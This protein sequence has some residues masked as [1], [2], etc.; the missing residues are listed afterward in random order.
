[1]LLKHITTSPAIRSLEEAEKKYRLCS[2]SEWN[3]KKLRMNG[4]LTLDDLFNATG[5]LVENEQEETRRKYFLSEKYL[6]RIITLINIFMFQRNQKHNE[7]INQLSM[8][9]RKNGLSSSGIHILQNLG[10]ASTPKTFSKKQASISD[11]QRPICNFNQVHWYDN[12]YRSLKGYFLMQGHTS[13]CY[14]AHGVTEILD[15]EPIPINGSVL[16]TP[17]IYRIFNDNFV[18]TT[19]DL[20]KNKPEIAAFP[21]L[22]ASLFLTLPLR[23][24]M[25]HPSR[26]KVVYKPE[27]VLE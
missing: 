9:M 26:G 21:L 25:S 15:S 18:T 24:P 19:I 7:E 17:H 10:L 3:K 11:Q 14:T 5:A 20:L 12:L 8:L 13:V 4:L 23:A 22:D 2:T 6:L 1:M 16:T 27:S